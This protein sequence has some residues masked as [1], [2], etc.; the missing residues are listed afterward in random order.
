MRDLLIQ[1]NLLPGVGTARLEGLVRAFESLA[2]FRRASVEDLTALGL[3]AEEAE[4]LRAEAQKRPVEEE[5]ARAEAA[6]LTLVTREDAAYPLPLRE[7]KGAPPVL[8]QCGAWCSDPDLPAIAVVGTRK[9]TPYGH[10]VARRLGRQLAEAGITVVSGMARGVDG[11]AHRG[12]LEAPGRT[13]AVLGCGLDRC[14]PP[15][16]RALMDG[17]TGS[18]AVLSEF[19]LGCPPFAANFP[20]RN[21]IISGLV[22]GVVVVEAAERSGSLI[23][24]RL[25]LE[26]GREV[27]AVPGP[28][29]SPYSRGTHALLRQGA[30]LLGGVEDI[31]EELDLEVAGDEAEVPLGEEE[32]RVLE[33]L[34]LEPVSVDRLVGK[35]GLPADRLASVLA[36]LE[37]KDRVRDVGGGR[38]V[39]LGVF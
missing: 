12:A 10:Q 2:A 5:M 28:I 14:Y 16:H 25:A 1:L 26:Q 39:G 22:R 24:A 3:P 19:P 36:L 20:R 27:F 11:A 13:V 15:E 33:H 35:T 8:Y 4:S 38:V 18:G 7:V 32:R 37:L 34:S 31:F 23:T 6:G 29:T 9:P 17:I 30:R 21:R